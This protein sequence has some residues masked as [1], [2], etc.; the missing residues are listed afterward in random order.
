MIVGHLQVV[1]RRH[2]LAVT[3]PGGHHVQWEFIGQLGLT[4]AAKILKRF[5][6]RLQPRSFDD[7]PKGRAEILRGTSVPGDD[8]CGPCDDNDEVER[9]FQA[10]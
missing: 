6:P 2:Q 7:F 10:R 5:R 8:V 4:R 9:A 1:L 3:D